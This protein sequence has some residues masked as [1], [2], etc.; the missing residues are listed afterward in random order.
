MK[1]LQRRK[2]LGY[3]TEEQET[4]ALLQETNGG[5]GDLI[6]YPTD[7]IYQGDQV[8]VDQATPI[9]TATDPAPMDPGGGVVTFGPTLPSNQTAPAINWPLLIAVAVGFYLITKKG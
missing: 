6:R 7:P 5:G 1:N 4:A 8:N 3:I 2:R 9:E